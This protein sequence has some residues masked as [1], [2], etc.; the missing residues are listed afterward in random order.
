MKNSAWAC[1]LDNP[2]AVKKTEMFDVLRTV[3]HHWLYCQKLVSAV[4][5]VCAS[6][7]T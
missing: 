2:T 6:Q 7:I 3:A 4:P 5:A 1:S